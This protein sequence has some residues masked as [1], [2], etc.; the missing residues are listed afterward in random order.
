MAERGVNNNFRSST[1]VVPEQSFAPQGKP[2]IETVAEIGKNIIQ[3]SQEA[4]VN[5][6]FSN[7]Q[8]EVNQ[9]DRQFQVEYQGDPFNK[10]GLE[11]L[12][13]NKNAIFDKNSEGISPFFMRPYNTKTRQL[14]KQSEIMTE[15]FGFK[16]SRVNTVNSMNK[17]IK[18]SLSQAAIDGESGVDLPTALNN[19]TTSKKAIVET[20]DGI[21]SESE[22]TAVLEDFDQDY[23]K[24]HLSG[25][26]VNDPVGA[27][28]MMD[29]KEVAESFR[30]RDQFVKMRD[31]I[32]NRALQSQQIAIK[33]EVL[34]AMKGSAELFASG[35][36]LSYAQVQTVSAN[37]SEPAKKF[38]MKKNGFTNPKDRK[39]GK[40]EQ[41]QF[42][43]SIVNTVE[44]I[45]SHDDLSISDLANL[46]GK[47]F[48]GMNN[49]SLSEKEGLTLMENLIEPAI[50]GKASRLKGFET[51]DWNPINNEI[52]Y[53]TITDFYRDNVEIRP[54]DNALFGSI[55]FSNTSEEVGPITQ[56]LNNTNKV[57]L[58][59]YY[60]ESL[61]E[62]AKK[63]GIPRVADLKEMV[64][65]DKQEVIYKAAADSAIN[66][67]RA[68]ASPLALRGGIP[69]GA[70][71]YLIQN[72]SN[73]T[74]FD[75]KY[76]T[77]AA[78]RILGR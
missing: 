14:G 34:G 72:P 35:K 65:S 75:K 77:G 28:A 27:L 43:A 1:K 19:F 45:M 15:A 22:A 36:P 5:E 51:S 29:T 59:D 31:A 20:V 70:I 21:L 41:L 52:G 18:N 12:K 61:K 55:L 58:F 54:E 60:F 4:K 38:F 11:T 30:D 23:L 50:E 64:D 6:N 62:Q 57:N 47:I 2:L 56:G 39:L 63:A 25:K 33:G 48:D 40:A 26:A 53:D 66:R 9:L 37:M 7:A 32:E 44:S 78:N 74:D 73:T 69:Q 76:G 71:N 67:F 10:K 16:Q 17:S 46:Q 68:N 42:K 8:F 24:T 49:N 3:R 13:K